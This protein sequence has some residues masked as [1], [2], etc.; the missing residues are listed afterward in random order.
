MR[1]IRL[2]DK[3]RRMARMGASVRK[4]MLKVRRA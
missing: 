2:S 1:R 3:G 4:T